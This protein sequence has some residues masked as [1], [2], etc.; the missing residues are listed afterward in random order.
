MK[1]KNPFI[2]FSTDFGSGNK[3]HGA[4]QGIAFKICPKARV[5][6]LSTN[7][8][9]FDIVAGAKVFEAIKWLPIGCHVCVVDPGVGTSRK[10]IVIQTNRGDYL[11]GPDNGVLIPAANFLGG[12]VKVHALENPKLMNQPVSNIF[13]GRDVFMPA[14]AHLANGKK[15]Q[16]FGRKLNPQELVKAPYENIKSNGK[17]IACTIID[18]NAE[19]NAFVNVLQK[20]F[21]E[22]A[23]LGDKII[24]E[25]NE[26]KLELNYK[27]TFGEVS[28]GELVILDDDFDGIEIAVNL[29]NFAEK[30]EV[31]RGQKIILRKG[32]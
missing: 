27:K 18:V 14:A 5:I 3:G 32:V 30:F 2:S 4:M 6:E 13:H 16:E 26:L 1:T 7:I 31:K 21:H 15:I 9:P 28:K 19:G 10:G 12:I 11:I 8:P 20:D 17:K 24:A 23:K 29:G 25:I 22:F